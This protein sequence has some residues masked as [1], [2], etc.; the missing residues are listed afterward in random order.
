MHKKA[1][2]WHFFVKNIYYVCQ[3]YGNVIK[4]PSTKPSKL[5]AEGVGLNS[6]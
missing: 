1:G 3:S 2:K 5:V 4:I 6:G